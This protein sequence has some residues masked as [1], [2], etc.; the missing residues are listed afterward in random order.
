MFGVNK[1]SVIKY[2][3]PESALRKYMELLG[4]KTSEAEE[5]NVEN[6]RQRILYNDIVAQYDLPSFNKTLID[7]YAVNSNDVALADS[8]NPTTLKV[9]GEAYAEDEEQ[10][11]ISKGEAVKISTGSMLPINTDAVVAAEDTFTQDNCV[12]IFKSVVMGE[13]IAKK[14]EDNLEA[15]LEKYNKDSPGN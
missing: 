3:S 10:I 1:E 12:K 14:G 9:V 7:G 11:I 4:D 6:S 13:N 2:E 8:D 5:I 15:F